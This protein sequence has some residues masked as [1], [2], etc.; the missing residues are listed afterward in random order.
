MQMKK[1]IEN[2]KCLN[3]SLKA[4][5]NVIT[6]FLVHGLISVKFRDWQYERNMKILKPFLEQGKIQ[7]LEKIRETQYI[8]S[9]L[10]LLLVL[11]LS[12][13]SLYFFVWKYKK[14]RGGE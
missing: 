10:S 6:I 11:I 3:V 9:M 1:M 12:I 14:E 13:F 2:D 8:E 5:T 7:I 4:M